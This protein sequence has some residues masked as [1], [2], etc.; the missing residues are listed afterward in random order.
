MVVLFH[1]PSTTPLRVHSD[2]YSY[3]YS[4]SYFGSHNLL[5]LVPIWP[6]RENFKCLCIWWGEDLLVLSMQWRPGMSGLAS[7]WVRF[8]HQMRQIRDFSISHFST[9]WLAEPLQKL[10]L[11]SPRFFLYRAYVIQ[12]GAKRCDEAAQKTLKNIIKR[13]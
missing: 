8:S 11:K 13:Q 5:N 7:K 6:K 1:P 2:S 9:F 12:S 10:I 4:D 3:S